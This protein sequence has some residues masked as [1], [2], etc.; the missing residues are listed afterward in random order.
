MPFIT[1]DDTRKVLN[2]ALLNYKKDHW[3]SKVEKLLKITAYEENLKQQ[4]NTIRQLKL[5]LL[6]A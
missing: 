6:R 2:T 4:I 3:Q 5:A 1:I